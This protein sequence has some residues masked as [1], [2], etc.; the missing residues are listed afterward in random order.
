MVIE[1]A[2]PKHV[3]E[4][5][6]PLE[7]LQAEQALSLPDQDTPPPETRMLAVALLLSGV[8]LLLIGAGVIALLRSF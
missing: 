2:P 4:Q 5:L 6:M 1:Q 3:T 8:M 7:A